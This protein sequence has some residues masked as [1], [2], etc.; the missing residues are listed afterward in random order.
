MIPDYKS[1]ASAI[2]RS[3]LYRR[4]RAEVWRPGELRE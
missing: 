4:E 3:C 1:D 2:G